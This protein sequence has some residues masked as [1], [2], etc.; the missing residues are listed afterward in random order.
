MKKVLL[1]VGC[2]VAGNCFSQTNF[3]ISVGTP[4]REDLNGVVQSADGNYIATGDINSSDSNYNIYIIKLDRSGQQIWNKVIS[5][6][7]DDGGRAITNTSDGGFSIGGAI[8]NKMA[9][10]KFDAAGNVTWMKQY[11]ELSTGTAATGLLQTDDGGY[12]LP[13]IIYKDLAVNQSYLVKT[14]ASGNVQWSKR[15]FDIPFNQIE[16]IKQTNDDNYVFLVSSYSSF[17]DSVRIVKINNSGSV[18]WCKYF[19]SPTPTESVGGYKLLPTSDGGY[20]VTGQASGANN[21]GYRGF[22]LKIDGNGNYI[23]SKSTVLASQPVYFYS[24]IE[25]SDGSYVAAGAWYNENEYRYVSCLVKVNSSGT[26][27]WTK[28][29]TIPGKDNDITAIIKSDDGGYLGIGSADNFENEN[30]LFIKFDSNFNTCNPEISFNSLIDFGSLTTGTASVHTGTATVFKDPVAITTTA[31]ILTNI[32]NALPLTLLDFRAA[33]QNKSVRLQWETSEEKNTAYFDVEKSNDGKAFARLT[34][35]NAAGNGVAVKSYAASDNSPFEGYNW[36]RLKMVDKDG[37]YA[38]SNILKIAFSNPKQVL[39]YP[40][41]ARDKTTLLFNAI[42][43][44]GYSIQ[45]TD[46]SGKVLLT[47]K[48]FAVA[49]ENKVKLD[50]N[51]YA[52]GIYIINFITEGTA[53]VSLKLNKE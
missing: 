45:L 39:L 15:Y 26:L 52:K 6:A 33:L 40:N 29:I 1:F 4:N 34:Q 28:A 44:G 21:S 16:D 47:I 23:W 11:N 24:A 12:L 18:L 32:C 17:S 49:G 5:T 46:I 37:Q 8:N 10:L 41:P 22:I 31:S 42:K 30:G 50:V 13:G 3:T 36:Y 43:A 25:T 14:D 27:L 9:I 38:Y 20:L 53:K 2:L 7:S 51:K 35:L 48:G 19:S